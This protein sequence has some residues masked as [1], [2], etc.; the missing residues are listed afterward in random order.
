MS[1]GQRAIAGETVWV[2]V[3]RV[4][5]DR[6]DD[7][8]A[9]LFDIKAPAVRG[10][11]PEAHATVRLLEPTA[12]NAD[13]TWPFVWIMDPAVPGEDYDTAS[14][15]DAYYGSE[16]AAEHMRRWEEL[17]ADDQAFYEMV[18]SDW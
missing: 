7:Y 3:D 17:C 2:C 10:I 15:L 13:G 4:R 12:P 14:I 18:Q 5:A 16:K 11:R 1:I 6:R 9:F 8:R